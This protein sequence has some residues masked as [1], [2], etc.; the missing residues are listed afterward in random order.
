M[1]VKKFIVKLT[2]NIILLFLN[3]II[4]NYFGL[5]IVIS[6]IVAGFIMNLS[7]LAFKKTEQAK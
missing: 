3:A 1:I 2:I 6:Y 5:S 7:D 4:F